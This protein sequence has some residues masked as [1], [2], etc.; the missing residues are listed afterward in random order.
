MAL[1][2][3]PSITKPSAGT[4]YMKTVWRYRK[5]VGMSESE[6]TLQ[7]QVTEWPGDAWQVDCQLP[8]MGRAEAAAWIAFLMQADGGL[9]T[10]LLGPDGAERLA[11]NG[12]GFATI[13]V[14]GAS[15][16]GK[17]ISLAGLDIAILRGDFLQVTHPDAARIY[18]VVEDDLGSSPSSIAIR[19]T[20]RSPSPANG[21]QCTFNFPVGT[22]RLAPSNSQEWSIDNAQVYGISFKAIEAI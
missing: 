8:P 10:F 22:F 18:M 6:F 12:E 14:D 20:L 9:N 16:T 2:T 4:G 1:I 17:S 11:Q 19:P 15:Q 13:T 3:L 7:Q 21:A 5:L